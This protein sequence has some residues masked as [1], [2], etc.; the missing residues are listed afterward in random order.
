MRFIYGM[1]SSYCQGNLRGV[2][3]HKV[4]ACE[5]SFPWARHRVLYGI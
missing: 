1:F 3:C 2:R 5:S 4:L